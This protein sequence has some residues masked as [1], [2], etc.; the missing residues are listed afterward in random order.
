MKALLD[1][2]GA[3]GADLAGIALVDDLRGADEVVWPEGAE[4][5]VVVALAH[6]PD[7]PEM[8]W[9][10]GRSDPPGNRV[11]AG[12][13]QGLCDWIPA[14]LGFRATHLP[15]HVDRGGAYLKDAAVL[16]G[17]GCIGLN[18]LL[19]TPQYGPRIRLRALTVDARLAPTGPIDFDPCQGCD[20]PCR[21]AC[22]QSAFGR[23]RGDVPAEGGA[24]R[25]ARTGDFSRSACYLQMDHDAVSATVPDSAASPGGAPPARP[26]LGAPTKV[27]RY[28]RACELSCRVGA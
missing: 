25:P 13:V 28:C 6:P 4:S 18:N 27:I 2:A 3:R 17:L 15:Y 8:D 11:L 12:I 21:D 16:A 1:Q 7:L 23:L 10:F 24:R 14:H 22:P 20:A 19:V 26:D 5:I 9:W